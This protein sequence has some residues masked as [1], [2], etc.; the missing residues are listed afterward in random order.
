MDWILKLVCLLRHF[1]AQQGNAAGDSTR[2]AI[3]INS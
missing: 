2:Q 1:T 3:S